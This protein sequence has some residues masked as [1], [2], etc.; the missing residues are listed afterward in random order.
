MVKDLWG[1]IDFALDDK[2]TPFELLRFQ[3]GL[4]KEKTKGHVL[5]EVKTYTEEGLIF[6]TLYLVVPNLDEY[7]YSLLRAVSLTPDYPLYIYDYSDPTKLRQLFDRRMAGLAGKPINTQNALRI[8]VPGG[9]TVDLD[10]P[11]FTVR[12]DTQFEDALGQ[13]LTCAAT[14]K[15]IRR[16][17]NQS[18]AVSESTTTDL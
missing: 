17:V 14:L 9:K 7:R 5:G 10:P 15:I 6:N 3:A 8:P 16:L 12:D 2:S 4:L 18:R 13:I 1:N 11:D